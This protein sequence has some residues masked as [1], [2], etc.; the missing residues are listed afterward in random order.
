MGWVGVGLVLAACPLRAETVAPPESPSLPAMHCT[1]EQT[2]GF[3]DYPDDGERYE[4]AL[5]HPQSFRLETNLVFM[6][7]LAGDESSADL[8]LTLTRELPTEEGGVVEEATELEC[9]RVRGGND[10]YG[11]SCVNLPPSEMMLLNARSLR[12]T[13]TAV[14]GWTFAGATDAHEGDS[15]FVEYGQCEPLDP[16]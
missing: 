11:F 1:A 6:M 14:G 7:N 2:G 16:T 4:P 5:F 15:I 3:H 9:R 10:D 12:F 8:Y 13:R